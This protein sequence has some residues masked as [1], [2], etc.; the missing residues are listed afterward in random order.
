MDNAENVKN[1]QKGVWFDRK[2]EVE[3]GVLSNKKQ[4][5]ATLLVF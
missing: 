2:E 5:T 4:K 1:R 3:A